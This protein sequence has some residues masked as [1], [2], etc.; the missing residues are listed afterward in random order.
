MTRPSLLLRR[1]I[2]PAAGAGIALLGAVLAFRAA[3]LAA[4]SADPTFAEDVAPIF[5]K[6]CVPCHHDGGMAPFSL[7][8]YDTAVAHVDQMRGAVAQGDMP[9]WHAEGPRGVFVNDRRL[10][11]ADKQTIIRWI[12]GGTKPGDFSHLPPKPDFP[13]AWTIGEPDAVVS[14][15]DSFT[16]PAA[17]KIDYQYFQVKTTFTEDKWL[18]AIEVRPSAREVVH[19]VLVYAFTP[20]PATTP[21]APASAAQRR[22][23][24]ARPAPPRPAPRSFAT[25]SSRARRPMIRA[26]TRCTRRRASS[27][28]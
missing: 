25:A 4:R 5:N 27:A 23:R 12:D 28:R 24:H 13:S 6:N 14:M 22:R 17:G 2:L 9:P 10:T 20:P 19:H 3:P 15:P 7:L 1:R 18:Q 26:T 8:N 21:S 16:V 11:D